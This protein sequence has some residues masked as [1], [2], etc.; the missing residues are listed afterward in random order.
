[1]LAIIVKTRVPIQRPDIG[2][3]RHGKQGVFF[4]VDL[5]AEDED[6]D[7]DLCDS[8]NFL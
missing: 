3:S 7:I 8:N 4:P 1:V 2:L 5:D 6:E